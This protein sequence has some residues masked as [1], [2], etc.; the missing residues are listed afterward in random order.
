MGAVPPSTTFTCA[1]GVCITE[2]ETDGVAEDAVSQKFA[3]DPAAG[4]KRLFGGL[5]RCD[6]A[7]GHFELAE[8]LERS[9]VGPV[10]MG[11]PMDKRYKA[12]VKSGT[13]SGAPGPVAVD[14]SGAPGAAAVVVV[15]SSNLS[16]MVCMCSSL[17]SIWVSALASA[18]LVAAAT[19][20]IPAVFAR[21]IS[22]LQ[23]ELFGSLLL[24]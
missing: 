22:L 16:K 18:P 4:P 17:L 6:P 24:A 12:C 10:D 13:K 15:L 21:L 7:V 9:D 14:A 20:S 5:N 1:T 11:I 19:W 3:A 2:P 23:A 8:E